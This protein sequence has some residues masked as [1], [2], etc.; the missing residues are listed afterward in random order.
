MSSRGSAWPPGKPCSARLRAGVG[1]CAAALLALALPVGAGAQ[2]TTPVEDQ[3]WAFS[4]TIS[5]LHSDNFLLISPDTPGDTVDSVSVGLL[6]GRSGERLGFSGYGRASGNY[7]QTFSQYNQLS[8]GGGLGL[9]YR[10]SP[11][12]DLRFSQ[13]ASSGLYTPVLIGLGVALP[14][15]RTDVARSALLATW[16]PGSRTTLTANGDFAYLH[17]SSDLSTLDAAQLP[18]DALILAGTIPAEQAEIGLSDLP[19]PVDASLLVLSALAGE[20]VTRRQLNLVT[21]HAGLQAEQTLTDRLT[22]AAQVGYRALDYGTPGVVRGGQLDAGAS[23]R[24]G[25]G[26]ST[27]ASLQYAYQQNRAQVPTVATHT[28]LLQVE[29]DLSPRLKIDASF[30]VGVAS[31]AGLPSSSGTSWLGGLGL[32]GRHRRTRYDARYGRS[33]YQAF[34]F[35]RNYLTDY[36]SVFVDQRLTRRLSG[37]LDARYRRSQDVFAQQFFFESQVYR[38][39]AGYRL[40]RRTVLGGYYSY[41]VIDRGAELPVIRKLGVGLLARL[42]PGLEV[43]RAGSAAPS[44]RAA[45]ASRA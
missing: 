38:V 5:Q 20:G 36:A 9:S 44:E 4:S 27:N 32:S 1:R 6:Y 23:L 40:Q 37:R 16:H 22:G 31:R 24:L 19:T 43:I 29:G 34:G 30:G 35:G 2:S 12:A 13:V 45:A 39:S 42:R 11:T 3:R 28:G 25:L 41:R 10:L 8:Y 26:P 14:Q 33:L 7:Y 21:Y 18:V 15:V 17:Y